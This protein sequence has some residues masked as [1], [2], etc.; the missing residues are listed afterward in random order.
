MKKMNSKQLAK[1][2]ADLSS[3]AVMLDMNTAVD[4]K[5]FQ[6]KVEAAYDQ[7]KD[8]NFLVLNKSFE[9]FFDYLSAI[10]AHDIDM[11][12]DLV[13]YGI[14]VLQESASASLDKDDCMDEVIAGIENGFKTIVRTSVEIKNTLSNAQTVE[15]PDFVTNT[16]SM[17]DDL[18]NDVLSMEKESLD[19]E[20]INLVFRVFHT[21]KGEAGMLGIL[22]FSQLAHS[23]ENLLEMVRTNQIEISSEFVS[24]I[25]SVVDQ[26]RYILDFL[27]KDLGKG[28]ELDV[29]DFKQKIDEFVANGLKTLCTGNDCKKEELPIKH[30]EQKAEDLYICKVPIIDVSDGVDMLCDFLT[31]SEDH[32]SCAEHALLFLE[33]CPEDTEAVDKIFRAFH[34]IKGLSSFFNLDDVRVLTHET[35]TMMDLVRKHSLKLDSVVVDTVLYAIDAARKLLFLVKEQVDNQG[36][37]FSL[38]YDV[39]PVIM[40]VRQIISTVHI[41]ADT[42][43][44]AKPKIGEIL[45]QKEVITETELDDALNIQEN[46]NRDKK[47]GEILVNQNVATVPQIKRALDAQQSSIVISQTIKVAVNKLDYLIDSVGELVI[48]GTQVSQNSI[49]KDSDDPKFLKDVAQLDKIIR[50]IQDISMSMRLVPIKPVFQKML[51]LV[52]DLSKKSNK[53]IDVGLNG[54][55]TEIDKNIIDLIG[56]P[57]MHMVRNAVDHGIESAQIRK[58]AGK[59]E[60]ARVELSAYH[61]GSNIVIEISDDGAGLNKDKILAKAKDK[62]IIND[63]DNISETKI[64]N[65]IFEPGFS[66]ADKV[67]DISGRGVGMD[68]VKKNIEQ[69]RGKVEISSEINKGSTFAIKLPLTLAIIDGIIL[70]LGE[71]HYIAPVFSIL[72]FIRP[73]L[74]DITTVANKGEMISVHGNLYRLIRLDRYF[75]LQAK[76]DNIE[77][78]TVCLVE[79][80]E[81]LACIVVD[82]VLGQ[83]QV[84]IKALG[85][86]LKD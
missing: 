57:L 50:D 32:L 22:N 8:N 23:M 6:D 5:Q 72:E 85:E 36:Q 35:E 37:L 3:A 55:D 43:V 7:I 68:V 41:A 84:V 71:E 69:L 76:Y 46:I 66:T 56:D 9:L 70:S 83:Q 86:R 82:G 39:S 18:E 42:E 1:I 52:R 45:I 13:S 14:D 53:A 63:L 54:E 47:I 75:N 51:R 60:K 77:D 61:H 38:Y 20:K 81:G 48:T 15:I 49:I 40:K 65:L 33:T 21:I 25:L 44:L 4:Y 31:E 67:T 19:H 27:S 29:S 16:L 28:L 2:I 58:E 80:D 24:L 78:A 10:D 73:R 34:T 64:F 11:V 79:S 17:L 59:Q 62:G 12:N 26:L 74:E 30:S